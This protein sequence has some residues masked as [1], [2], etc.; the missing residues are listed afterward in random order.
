MCW[1][2]LLVVSAAISCPCRPAVPSRC[3]PSRGYAT[4]WR[5]TLRRPCPSRRCMMSTSECPACCFSQCSLCDTDSAGAPLVCV[6]HVMD[7]AAVPENAVAAQW[8]TIFITTASGDKTVM[9]KLCIIRSVAEGKVQVFLNKWI[10]VSGEWMNI[11]FVLCS[12]TG[13]KHQ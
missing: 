9:F 5:S 1:W 6:G 2:A 10:L 12:G 11:G 3:T 13:K 4:P 8:Q 7:P